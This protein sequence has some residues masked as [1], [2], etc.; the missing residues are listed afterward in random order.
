MSRIV[1]ILRRFV[2][3]AWGGTETVV[4]QLCREQQNAGHDVEIVCTSALSH[5]GY[6]EVAGVPVRRFP[7]WYANWPLTSRERFK[8][9]GKGGNPLSASL[10]R[11]LLSCPRPDLLHV[12]VE[13]RLGAIGRFAAGR[14]G[15]PYVV[16]FHG[17]CYDV[18]P[19]ERDGRQSTVRH[20]LDLGK[21]AG[22][23]LGSRRLLDD[24]AALLFVNEADAEHAATRF[25][26]K[27]VAHL[28][29]GVDL[30]RW[31][32]GDPQRFLDHFSL[33]DKRIVLCVARI[34]PQKDQRTLVRAFRRVAEKEPAAHLVLIGPVSVPG[35]DRELRGEVHVG[36]LGGRVTLVPGLPADSPLL[37][38][39]YQAAEV[40]VLPSRHE[41]FGIAALEAWAARRPLVASDVGGL[42]RLVRTHGGGL[43][44]PAGDART[45]A[46]RITELLDSPSRGHD[47]ATRGF[48]AAA[49]EYTWPAIA[50]RLETIYETVWKEQPKPC[51]SRRTAF[52]R[53]AGAN[54]SANGRFPPGRCTTSAS[55]S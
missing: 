30:A 1:H 26:D 9:D 17:G 21:P 44:F 41:P 48:R 42:G 51:Q 31:S 6:D 37:A 34:D 39:A 43:L 10:L 35:Y 36:G 18:P 14:R 28:P 7:Y 45:L 50:G 2:P 19:A 33:A 52:W 3:A 54:R 29:N 55:S 24:A 46:R 38:G 25:P 23:L 32:A 15:A 12:H 5:A 11:Y 22:W 40:C 20:K 16:S 49:R 27:H 47:L 4:T 13:G 8:L 53:S